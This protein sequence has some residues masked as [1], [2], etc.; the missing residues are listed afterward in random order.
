MKL[1]LQFTVLNVACIL[2][3][4]YMA[5]ILITN[6]S[7]GGGDNLSNFFPV[8]LIICGVIG[9]VIDQVL[10]A[11]IPSMTN[12]NI[13]GGILVLALVGCYFFLL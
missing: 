10:Q 4:I 3:I 6:P 1:S 5:Y 7:N 2:F 9:L 11:Y 8:V 12:V 13:I